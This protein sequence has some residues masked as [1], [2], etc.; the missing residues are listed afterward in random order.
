MRTPLIRRL[1]GAVD[2]KRGVMLDRE[3]LARVYTAARAARGA[4]DPWV[5]AMRR[6]VLAGAG[7]KLDAKAAA[8]SLRL[9]DIGE[10]A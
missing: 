2:R 5:D 3:E 8:A 9:I 4:A 10:S 1:R 6:A 7:F